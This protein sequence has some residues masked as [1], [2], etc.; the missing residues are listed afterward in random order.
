MSVDRF[1]D[2]RAPNQKVRDVEGIYNQYDY[3]EQSKV[4]LNLWAGL[5]EG[6]HS[7]A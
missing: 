4:T 2:E 5:I 7:L 1:V 3:F 6:C